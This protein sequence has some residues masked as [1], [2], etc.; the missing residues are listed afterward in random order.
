MCFAESAGA[1]RD[2]RKEEAFEPCGGFIEALFERFE[3]VHVEFF[4]FVDVFA[5]A[6]EDGRF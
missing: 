4:G 1:A 2:K 3:E 6:V 5:D